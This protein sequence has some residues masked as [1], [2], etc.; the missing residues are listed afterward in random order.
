MKTYRF[1]TNAKC[2]GCVSN[3]EWF[4]KKIPG[5]G[6]WKIDL[7]SPDK[8]L[9]IQSENDLTAEVLD[10]VKKAGYQAEPLA[11]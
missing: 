7:Q 6:T 3:I 8:V 4:L 1:R 5:I 11:V 2:A 10:A 9:E